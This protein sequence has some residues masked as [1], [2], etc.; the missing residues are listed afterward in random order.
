MDIRDARAIRRK[1]SVPDSKRTADRDAAADYIETDVVADGR[2]PVSMTQIAQE[3][4]YSRQHIANV[5]EYYFEPTEPDRDPRRIEPPEDVAD[6][7]SY[8][9]GFID[10]Y[11]DAAEGPR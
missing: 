3:T 1:D 11:R 6:E 8:L 7:G 9:R 5:L 2:W 4:N 10:G